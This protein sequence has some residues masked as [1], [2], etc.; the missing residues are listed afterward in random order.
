M[1]KPRQSISRL[2]PIPLMILMWTLAAA[3]LLG[4]GFVKANE[5]ATA[6]AEADGDK[7]WHVLPEELA[8]VLSAKAGGYKRRALNFTCLES[9]RRADYKD[10][11]A[12][13]EV[14]ASYAYLLVP[15][16]RV[17]GGFRS[18]RTRPQAGADD[19][20][21]ADL[22][23][24]EPYTWSQ[25]FDE[26]IRS[27]LK[28]KIGEWRTTPY[29][30]VLP[31]SWMASTP[32]LNGNWIT[33]YSGQIEIERATAN[34]ITVTASP[35]LQ[36]EKII[37]EM[38]RYLT[39]FRILGFSTA[40]P[41]IGREI[42]VRFDFEHNGYTY[43]TRVSVREFK[44][45]SRESREITRRQV[46]DYS[47]YRFFRTASDPKIPPLLYDPTPSAPLPTPEQPATEDP[48]GS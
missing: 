35:N 17:P 6:E 12:Q 27:G 37:A 18:Y 28:F 20:I 45:I 5:T 33:E 2:S 36:E 7:L 31:V 38:D 10:S 40:S 3:T 25:L 24:P 29:K 44:Q 8:E 26:V 41:P 30:L 39:A 19:E 14:R 22:P 23:F 11:E 9:I 15:D 47:D 1:T 43:P 48:A 42:E 34:P 32:T 13:R 16:G 46:V 4:F 21:Q